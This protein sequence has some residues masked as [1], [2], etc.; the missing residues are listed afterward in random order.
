MQHEIFKEEYKCLKKTRQ[1]L[2]KQS[3]LKKLNPIIDED[4]LLRVGGHLAPASVTK[5]E[6][7][8]I[9]I[10]RTHHIATLLVRYYHEKV[11]HRG[12]HI[13]EGAIRAAGFWIT[14]SKSLV[15]SVNYKSVIC[16]RLRGALQI[17]KMA[18]LPADRLTPMAPFT[19]VGLD[20]FGPLR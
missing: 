17:Q 16:C 15:S 14:G 18:D 9:I 4:G 3:P 10:P 13:T 2:P 11:A 8:P 20:V 7:H 6:K 5:E 19:N 1:T 12:H